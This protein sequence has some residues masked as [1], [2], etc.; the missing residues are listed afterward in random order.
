MSVPTHVGTGTYG[1]V[2]ETVLCGK[3]NFNLVLAVI[4]LFSARFSLSHLNPCTTIYNSF[5]IY[6][7]VL[8]YYIECTK[9]KH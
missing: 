9:Y 8:E 5:I 4:I 6:T 7:V 1:T 2:D 3:Q